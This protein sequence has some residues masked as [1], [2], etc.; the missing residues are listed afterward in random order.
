MSDLSLP[1]DDIL[2]VLEAALADAMLSFDEKECTTAKLVVANIKIGIADLYLDE[3]KKEM[4][5]HIEEEIK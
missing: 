3:L 2:N 1:M 4:L 5:I